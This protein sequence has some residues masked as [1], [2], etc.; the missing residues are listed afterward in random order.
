MRAKIF[1]YILVTY[2]I[3]FSSSFQLH[4]QDTLA[5]EQ[6]D[7]L[8][9]RAME[10]VIWGQ[11][12]EGIRGFIQATQRD[13]GGDW[14]DVV[15]FT[16]P[17]TTRH[18][19]L[20]ANDNVPY[21]ATALNTKNG[22]MVIEVPAASEK[23]KFFGSIIDAWQ[24]PIADVGPTGDDKGKG[25]KY[26]ILPPGYEGMVPKGY[27]SY[28]PATF[29][30]Y[31][32]FRTVPE[33][34]GTLEDTVEYAQTLKVYPLAKAD[35]PPKTRFI[36]AYPKKW[37]T[38]PIY[39]IT[40]FQDLADVINEE[41]VQERDLAM[42]AML[43]SIGIK[44]GQPFEPS[45]E[46][47]KILE[48]AVQD[49]Y[50]YMQWYFV[51]GG[52]LIPYWENGYWM[53]WN[54]PV[55]QLKLGFPFST[56][57]SLLTDERAGGLYFFATFMPK[58][59]GGGTF[60]LTGVRDS[61]GDLY[62]GK[63]TYR[64]TVPADTPASDFW[65]VIAYSMKNK[66]FFTNVKRIGLSSLNMKEMKVKDDGSVD[67][68]F[69]PEAPKGMESNWVPTPED[70]MLLFRLYGPGKLL[71]DKSWKLPEMVKIN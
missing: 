2:I 40:Y 15:Y 54:I 12:A 1:D 56:D 34:D 31:V 44:K 62:S 46:M 43:E 53:Q 29:A 52:A 67:I 7:M 4:A 64:L 30:T 24:L 36:D 42:M 35:N 61:E 21:V 19:F 60:Y 39:D 17:M 22:P 11:P 38:L 3:I 66:G 26:L 18:G 48:E 45:A 49:A 14:N 71:F 63:S 23:A 8:H 25:A 28:R 32:G 55:S 5:K 68:Y 16:K 58:R 65:S 59:L 70:F 33:G 13:L 37:N 20:T 10:V 27:I 9:R 50:D 69:G 6:R 57:N 41:P 47:T 51:E